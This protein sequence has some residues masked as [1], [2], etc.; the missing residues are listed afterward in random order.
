[1][2]GANQI[3]VEQAV[4]P[5]RCATA[6]AIE[7]SQQAKG[8]IKKEPVS[9]GLKNKKIRGGCSHRQPNQ[10]DSHTA[11]YYPIEVHETA[12][13]TRYVGKEKREEAIDV[14]PNTVA[15]ALRGRPP[16]LGSTN[17]MLTTKEVATECHPYN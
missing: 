4:E 17:V 9:T 13:L 5:A 1:M 3:T 7:A 12:K 16:W 6:R 8:T 15:A 14:G 10:S 2:K 11:I